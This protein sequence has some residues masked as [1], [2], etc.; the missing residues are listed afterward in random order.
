MAKYATK[1]AKKKKE[2]SSTSSSSEKSSS[3]GASEAGEDALLDQSKIRMMHRHAPGLL[4]TVGVR[5]MQQAVTE[6]EG[7]WS[8]ENAN[9]PP[10]CLRY[11]RSQLG[12][13]LT[14]APLKE[15]LTLGSCLDLML[16]A[17]PAEACDYMMQ[18]LKALERISQGNSW[19]SSEKLELAPH[20][21]P[22]ISTFAEV[23]DANRELKLEG[24]SRSPGFG[25][26]GSNSGKGKKGKTEDKGKGK[27]K[28]GDAPK[29]S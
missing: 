8:S 12:G 29:A 27:R 22:Q 13:K 7:V 4:T 3:S 19:Q 5:R 26:K 11:V 2:V 24:T 20:Q 15:A 25:A 18:R 9:L 17:R 1:K 16:Q 21:L 28:G 23:K 6:M 10:L 14:G